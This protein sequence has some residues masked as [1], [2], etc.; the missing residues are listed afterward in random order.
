MWLFNGSDERHNWQ[1]HTRVNGLR[2]IP[3]GICFIFW[4][5][6]LFRNF[7]SSSSMSPLS[8]RIPPKIVNLTKATSVLFSPTILTIF[9][10][11]FWLSR[12]SARDRWSTTEDPWVQLPFWYH[13]LPRC[14]YVRQYTG[15]LPKDLLFVLSSRPCLQTIFEKLV[16]YG[17]V[18]S[19]SAF[20]IR[21]IS[22]DGGPTS[23]TKLNVDAVDVSVSVTAEEAKKRRM[24]RRM[25]TLL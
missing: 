9:F 3:A 22:L 21:I 6:V 14:R 11:G 15:P 5:K 18:V 4:I 19:D 12:F 13:A 10:C 17:Y 24:L 1:A 25:T 23:K 7:K 2:P 20:L 8:V 16:G